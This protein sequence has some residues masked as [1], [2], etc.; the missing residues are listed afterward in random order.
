MKIMHRI[1]AIVTV[2]SALLFLLLLAQPFLL[3]FDLFPHQRILS[4]DMEKETSKHERKWWKEAVAYEIYPASFKDSN[5]DGIGDIPGIV[6]KLDYLSNLG[7]DVIHICPHYQSPQVD[8]GYDVSDYEAIHKPYGTVEDVQALIDATHARGMKI[9]FD[10]VINHSSN[11]H[12]W[13]KESRSSKDNPKR[14]WY[15]WRPPK[16]DADGNR[17][18]PNNWRSHFTGPAWTWDETTQEYYLHVYA[19]E[20]PD[21]NWE[22]EETRRA[23]YNTSI[24][25]WLERGIDGFRIDTVN[26]YSKDISFPD[27]KITDPGKETQPA[28]RY[29]NHGPRIYE[30]LGEMKTIFERY[31]AMTVGELSHLPRDEERVVEF[32][33]AQT[34]PLNMVF[35][36]DLSNL[37]QKRKGSQKKGRANFE[38]KSFKKEMSRWQFLASNPDA[39]VTL[40]LEN[41][42]APRSISRFDHD[43]SLE[44]QVRVGK[45]FAVIMATMTGT[46]FLYQG[47][48]IGMSNAPREWAAEEYKDVRSG[49]IWKES[50]ERCK[51]DEACLASAL[52]DLWMTAR[53]H[54][55]LPMQWSGEANAGFASKDVTPWMRVHDDYEKKNAELQL[56]DPDSLLYFWKKIL[57]L[58]K[59]YKD[60]FIY[61]RYELVDTGKNLFVFIK[62]AGRKSLTVVNFSGSRKGWDGPESILGPNY[63]L[64]IG[65]AEGRYINKLAAWEARVYIQSS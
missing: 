57:K 52:G 50:E 7:V 42:D 61:G 58:R 36:F 38:L 21:F 24:I 9:I 15:F 56:Q 31:D 32:V 41:H 30:F 63:K 18:P 35:Q 6:S 65:T 2:A 11:L 60:L 33:S 17:H 37:G 20:M 64:L 25:F 55:R 5:D 14:D 45:M 44:D 43:F 47:Q 34:G 1:T 10:L 16:I 51:G 12:K 4:L 27:A 8:M 22:N 19:P 46:L 26:K 40:G 48:E 53:D 54:S 28:S 39:W 62:E 49:N 59:E 23:I 29:Y 13:F 3:D